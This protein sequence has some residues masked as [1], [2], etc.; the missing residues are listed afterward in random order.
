MRKI[1]LILILILFI[2]SKSISWTWVWGEYPMFWLYSYEPFDRVYTVTI[3]ADQNYTY[4]RMSISGLTMNTMGY[5][6]WASPD[7]RV[8]PQPGQS[9]GT[10]EIVGMSGGGILVLRAGDN[11]PDNPI[12]QGNH[13]LRIWTTV[14]ESYFKISLEA[15]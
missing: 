10:P 7:G 15:E 8:F 4:L 2:P 3:P 11:I 14:E 5:F 6:T 12:P 9:Q 1:I 13:I